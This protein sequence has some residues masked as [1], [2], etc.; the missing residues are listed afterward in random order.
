MKFAGNITPEAG[1]FALVD[2]SSLLGYK[3]AVSDTYL[4]S[5]IDILYYFFRAANVKL[6]TGDSF[7]WPVGEQVVA[8][9]SFAYEK[10]DLVRMMYQI[11]YAIKKL[12]SNK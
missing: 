9:M 5:E 3:D 7:A 6:L 11:F 4:K 10:E 8:R 2:F 12:D 1:F